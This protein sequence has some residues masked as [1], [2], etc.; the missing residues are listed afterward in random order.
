MSTTKE[1]IYT[2]DVETRKSV[3]CKLKKATIS[4]K[5]VLDLISIAVEKDI[6]LEKSVFKTEEYKYVV[7]DLYSPSSSTGMYL[8]IT[9]YT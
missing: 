3:S 4:P 6:D 7:M 5:D 1:G 9:Q 2:V 8:D